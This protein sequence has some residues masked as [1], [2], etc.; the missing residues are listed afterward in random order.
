MANKHRLPHVTDEIRDG[1]HD[2]SIACPIGAPG[3]DAWIGSDLLD[4][5]MALP[6]EEQEDA[7]RAAHERAPDP[8]GAPDRC[9][10]S[11]AHVDYPAHDWAGAVCMNCGHRLG[12]NE[13][14]D[15]AD[16]A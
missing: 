6:E 14:A 7:I 10:D 2:E 8:D 12:D 1:Q 13:E 3:P 16:E 5:I 11:A 4:R 9:Y 15:E